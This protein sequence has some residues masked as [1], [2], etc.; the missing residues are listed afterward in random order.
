MDGPNSSESSISVH[1]ASFADLVKLLDDLQIYLEAMN[2][3][4]TTVSKEDEFQTES[5]DEIMI[6]E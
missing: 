2:V 6:K 3:S 1:G 5:M 4:E